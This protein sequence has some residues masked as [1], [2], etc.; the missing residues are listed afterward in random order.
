MVR[1]QRERERKSLSLSLS[2][3]LKGLLLK[4]GG[5]WRWPILIEVVKYSINL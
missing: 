4:K 1:T 2:L 3:S 5:E